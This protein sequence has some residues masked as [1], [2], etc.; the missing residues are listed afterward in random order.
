MTVLCEDLACKDGKYLSRP[1]TYIFLSGL[2]AGRRGYN[3]NL[4]KI[5]PSL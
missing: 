4:S 1:S 5:S 2:R 3:E